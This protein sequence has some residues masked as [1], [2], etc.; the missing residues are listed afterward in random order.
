[1]DVRA[2][3]EVSRPASE[4]FQYLADGE[5]MPR[6]MKEFTSVEKVGEGPI[7]PGTEFRYHDKRGTDSTFEWSQYQ[8]PGRLAWHGAAVKMPGGSVEPDGYYDIHEH[9][10]HTHI[11]MHMQ[12]QLH[13][14]AK[15]MRPLMARGMRKSSDEYVKL[16][17]ADLEGRG[18]EGA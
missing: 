1:M 7:G 12:P 13:G 6:W 8:P 4:V 15:L 11:E 10:G 9:D 17:K 18:T 5:K 3:V 2:D 16:L 14:L